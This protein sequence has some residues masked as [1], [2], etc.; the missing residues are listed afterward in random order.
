MTNKKHTIRDCIQGIAALFVM[1]YIMCSDPTRFPN[2]SIEI[3]PNR[4]L[5]AS[6]L[7]LLF[8]LV[9]FFIEGTKAADRNR[10]GELS[11]VRRVLDCYIPYWQ[12][13]LP[14][15]LIGYQFFSGKVKSRF[16]SPMF[17]NPSF[18]NISRALVALT[19]NIHEG[20][21]L[22]SCIALCALS[23]AL[24]PRAV[25]RR[26]KKA[27][28]AVLAGGVLAAA[29]LY[30]E[31]M[32]FHYHKAIFPI[33]AVLGAVFHMAGFLLWQ[34]DGGRLAER[35]AGCA[36]ARGGIGSALT[37][38]LRYIG[39][40]W[41][42]FWVLQFFPML[43]YYNTA[44]SV[45]RLTNSYA[46]SFLLFLAFNTC[47]LFTIQWACRMFMQAWRQSKWTA[48]ALLLTLA[49]PVFLHFALEASVDYGIYASRAAKQWPFYSLVSI[50]GILCVMMLFQALT[51][52]WLAA[53]LITSVLLTILGIANHYTM[54]YHGTLLT[55]EDLANIRTAAN[56]AGGYDFSIDAVALRILLLGAGGIACTVLAWLLSKKPGR[57]VE[58]KQRWVSRA[59]CLVM[60]VCVFFTLYLGDKPL[61]S[62]KNN[63]WNWIIL[64]SKIGYFSGT[65]QSTQANL[66]FDVR[67]PDYYSDERIQELADEARKQEAD[68]AGTVASEQDYP[69]IIMILNET[70]YDLEKY[71][72]VNADVDYMK[73]YNALGNAIKGY[74]ETPL[75][76]GGTNSSEYEM[77]TGNST[78]LINAYSPYNRLDF[79]NQIA[80][81]TYL[82]QFGYS[83][84]AAHPLYAQNYQRGFRWNQL[85]FD[86]TYFLEDFTD[87]EYYGN[88]KGKF[89]R[90]TDLSAI[91][92]LIRFYNDMPED[93][94]R[95]AFMITIQSHGSWNANTPDQA[96]VHCALDTKDQELIDKVNEYVSCIKLT[97]DMIEY[98]QSYFDEQYKATGR[99]VIVCMAGDH[100]PSMLTSMNA[101]CKWDDRYYA[102][103]MG[104]STPYFIWANYPMDMEA[105]DLAGTDDMDLTCLMPTML[106]VA[107]VPLSYYYR[108]ILDMRKN[109]TVFTNVGSSYKSEDNDTS[110][111][112]R[113][114]KVHSVE[115][116]SPLA[117]SVKDYYTMEYNLS[118][119]DDDREN[120]LF[121]PAGMAS[122]GE[123]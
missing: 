25:E 42:A 50:A 34:R 33:A 18:L 57:A 76:G 118:A 3:E 94:P 106:D 6:P 56:V 39:R 108:H 11:P 87:L 79:S 109:I 114:G 81:P 46:L 20:A 78:S 10:R 4:L 115:E 111:W 49:V 9:L 54:V 86:R 97:D 68:G 45:Y 19:N 62:K 48:A 98:M 116:N 82:K 104:R 80:L 21:W 23:A 22:V 14:L 31:I 13:G 122:E 65:V 103:R 2:D 29:A 120:A 119:M 70:Y 7:F 93:G 16:Y 59:L 26:G 52:R 64:Y 63:V 74:T 99:K 15:T 85:K 41:V 17:R 73:N 113:N 61:S 55:V 90:C 53:G 75:T 35:E 95:F 112:D 27:G 102:Q 123:E 91:K 121:L 110:F 84:I 117:Q 47:L 89:D 37:T 36:L 105:L 107:G 44:A 8:L 30:L 28:M 38:P 88:R 72:D 96:L 43:Y 100:G 92:N 71:I 60:S 5:T 66:A 69:D 12:V 67:K 24:Y 58:K 51:G 83:A 1:F 32:P 40:N 101:L 77:L